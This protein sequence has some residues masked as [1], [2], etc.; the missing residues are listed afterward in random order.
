MQRQ[1]PTTC[2]IL[3]DANRDVTLPVVRLGGHVERSV[4]ARVERRAHLLDPLRVADASPEEVTPA[5]LATAVDLPLPDPRHQRALAHVRRV[6]PDLQVPPS[7]RPRCRENK[8]SRQLQCE[9]PSSLL[10][11]CSQLA[12]QA[13]GALPYHT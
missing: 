13:P 8:C 2:A 6:V 1:V 3:T 5:P 4:A 12:C 7:A 11:P 10:E 9:V